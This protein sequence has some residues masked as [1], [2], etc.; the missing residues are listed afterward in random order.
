MARL[1]LAGF[2]PSKSNPYNLLTAVS[3]DVLD[4]FQAISS[5]GAHSKSGLA[6][7][8]KD[9]HRRKLRKEVYSRYDELFRSVV[10]R[11]LRMK[12][13]RDDFFYDQMSNRALRLA[14]RDQQTTGDHQAT[15]SLPDVAA[16]DH[17]QGPE[18]RAEAPTAA[19]T[20]KEPTK[21]LLLQVGSL[22]SQCPACFHRTSPDDK[23]PVI[24]S[25]DGN[26]Q[27]SR[28]SHVAKTNLFQYDQKLFFN[29]PFADREKV[30][31]SLPDRIVAGT[32]C[33]HNFKATAK[34]KTM[35][36]KDETGLLMI[37]C[38]CVQ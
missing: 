7:G 28:Y 1:I 32:I 30:D 4:L 2:F 25:L 19:H 9:F 27:Q 6:N 35:T 21:P 13:L 31:E 38:R 36:F 3:F 8:L 23:D 12:R 20:A 37:V 26:M 18:S 17:N 11:Y 5:H 14:V 10:P 15:H 22:V 34:P 24:I 16:N 33:E 29:V